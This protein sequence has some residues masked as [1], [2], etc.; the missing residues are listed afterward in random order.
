MNHK[1][2][3]PS[4]VADRVMIRLPDGM[5]AK[6]KERAKSAY[7]SVNGEIVMLIERGMAAETKTASEHQA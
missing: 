4:R 3:P 6:L 7:R 2:P 1:P 5:H